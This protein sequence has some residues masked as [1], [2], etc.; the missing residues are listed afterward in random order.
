MSSDGAMS[1][2]NR[3]FLDGLLRRGSLAATPGM[4]ISVGETTEYGIPCIRLHFHFPLAFNLNMI[5]SIP[6]LVPTACLGTVIYPINFIFYALIEEMIGWLANIGPRHTLV[7]LYRDNHGQPLP[8]AYSSNWQ[9]LHSGFTLF[10]SSLRQ[11][12]DLF[13]G[14]GSISGAFG[15]IEVMQAR[16]S[17]GEI[18]PDVVVILTT[19]DNQRM[20][21]FLPRNV[22]KLPLDFTLD[23]LELQNEFST[24]V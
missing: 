21:L 6:V 4:T 1:G 3:R 17:S 8:R 20:S 23:W 22:T 10:I 5:Q 12:N 9:Q 19:S 14:L 11:S 7:R 18:S 15:A 16:T 24:R 2:M 13:P